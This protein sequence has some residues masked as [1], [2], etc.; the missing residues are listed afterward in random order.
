ML[1]LKK[2]SDIV[3]HSSFKI[4]LGVSS[5]V[6]LLAGLSIFIHVKNTSVS[7][8][9]EEGKLAMLDIGQGDS[10]FIEFSANQKLLV[11]TGDEKEKFMA[12]MDEVDNQSS[13][14]INPIYDFLIEKILKYKPKRI[15]LVIIT[16]DHK[17]HVGIIAD[18]MK[19]Y[20]VG[21]VLVSPLRYTQLEQQFEMPVVSRTELNTDDTKSR[22]TK[23]TSMYDGHVL[24]I[25]RHSG[26]SK[27]SETYLLP[28]AKVGMNISFGS[29]SVPSS[30]MISHPQFY[31]QVVDNF[32]KIISKNNDHIIDVNDQRLLNQ[33]G[34]ASAAP[35][36]HLQEMNPIK[37]SGEINI[38]HPNQND[39]S[40]KLAKNIKD[41]ESGNEDSI[42]FEL[43]INPSVI[44]GSTT[45]R[46]TTAIFT[47]DAG[48]E[49]EES[50][51]HYISKENLARGIDFLKVGHH[52]SKTSTSEN[53]INL[54][55]P[56]FALISLGHKNTYGHPH[57][58][59]LN[60]LEHHI[61]RNQIFRTDI[62][63]TV[64][65]H[66]NKNGTL[67]YRPCDVDKIE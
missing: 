62:C 31:Q 42:V 63:G 36:Q 5:L 23:T 57:K 20:S 6:F 48:V 66:I 11:D 35:G 13:G 53:L 52:G 50:Y 32:I 33:S 59:V 27:Y 54:L 28:I 30:T 22:Q 8:G 17:D 29:R 41:Q 61:P 2:F 65:F 34:Y 7:I 51:V 12:A 18:I 45:T 9:N 64:V 25:Y 40:E 15:D 14:P 56:Q 37:K 43:V 10:F 39:V 67:R 60:I 1:Q 3:Y 21:A 44:L 58:N 16:H 26:Q 4:S 46:A 38:L 49:S 55:H 19:M 24:P 47:G